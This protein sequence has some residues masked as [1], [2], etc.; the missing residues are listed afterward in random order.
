MMPKT[1]LPSGP[2]ELEAAL[3]DPKRFDEVI[4]DPT[5]LATWVR[6]YAAAQARADKDLAV[7]I[8]EQVQNTIREMRIEAG[9]EPTERPQLFRSQVPV[10]R[11]HSRSAYAAAQYNP[12]SPGALLDKHELTLAGFVSMMCGDDSLNRSKLEQ[13]RASYSSDIPSSGGI[14]VPETIR[15]DLM[16]AA[17]E[18]SVVRPR[19]TVFP[20]PTAR[21]AYPAVDVTSHASSV[22]GGIVAYWTAEAAPLTE[23]QGQ[24][25]T[26]VFDAKKLTAYTQVPNE[27]I[28]DASAAFLSFIETAYPAALA[29]FADI[30][31]L[32]GTGVGEPLGILKSTSMVSVAKEAGQPADTIVWQNIVKMYSRMLPSSLGRAVWLANSNVIPEL[33]TMAL[34]VGTGGS[35]IWMNNG[36]SS[37][38]VTIMGR[39][40]YFT[41]KLPTLGD[42]GDIVFIDPTYYGIGD[43]QSLT[44]SSS[45]HVAYATDQTAFRVIERLDGR[46]LVLSPLTPVKGS[47]TLSPFV[48]IAERA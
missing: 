15:T 23:S 19:A 26:V 47:T 2:A 29:H 35:A 17:L 18:A 8:R 7:Q 27:L 6:D 20:M 40:V 12:N 21:V 5:A 11:G 44:M 16:M 34:S 10:P 32:S 14:L 13:Y 3:S 22:F 41:E 9:G 43:R 33:A 39:P 30:A 28:A 42:A 45:Q 31:F 37:P 24:F 36:V 25:G 46:P 4:S 38:P 48:Q 1:L